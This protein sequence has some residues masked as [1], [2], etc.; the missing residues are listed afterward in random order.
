MD[1]PTSFA[2]PQAATAEPALPQREQG[3]VPP[4]AHGQPRKPYLT[5]RP[6]SGWTALN[7][8]DLWQ[9]SNLLLT[10]A[11][12][13]VTLRYRQTALGVSWVIL[14]PLLA[15]AIFTFVFRQIAG[16]S[17]DGVPYFVFA[18]TGLI[19]WNAFNSTLSKASSSLVGNSQ[20]ISKVF[21]P[22]LILPLST[23]FSTLI[24]AGVGLVVMVLMML[25][26][27]LVPSPAIL[28]LPLILA[29]LILLGVGVGLYSAALMVSYR[30]LQYVIPVLLQFVL[31][32]SPVAYSMSSVPERLQFWLYLNPLSGLLQAFRW[33]VFGQGELRWVFV[34][35]SAAVAA[36]V[37]VC[38]AYAFKRM[39][40]RFADVI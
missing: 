2:A 10:L 25:A 15:A 28:L 19:G 18:F 9:Y 13:D 35:Y 37:F 14:Q 26:A 38:G 27:G 29:L 33:S 22:R 17:S 23:V 30:D 5:I 21:F 16:L 7:L 20:L 8:I 39:E 3:D 11:R 40:R 32:A 4:A 12:R 36:A 34:A 24:D 31:Y 1:I 6:P